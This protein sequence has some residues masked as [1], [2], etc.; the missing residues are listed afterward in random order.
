MQHVH[1]VKEH[2][3]AAALRHRCRNCGMEEQVHVVHRA[4]DDRDHLLPQL[5]D[6]RR[7]QKLAI[8]AVLLPARS[9][10][11][12][13]GSRSY[14][15][16]SAGNC[17]QCHHTRQPDSYA[18]AGSWRVGNRVLGWYLD[19]LV[20]EP[21]HVDH[22][23]GV[24]PVEI[25]LAGERTERLA[26]GLGSHASRRCTEAEGEEEERGKSET[27]DTQTRRRR[28]FIPW[29]A[30]HPATIAPT[31]TSRLHARCGPGTLRTRWEGEPAGEIPPIIIRVMNLLKPAAT[32]I[33]SK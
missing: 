23:G 16:R 4:P 22:A 11:H 1:R 30:R 24:Q 5:I 3:R 13:S 12:D 9:L 21:A 25:D 31:Y 17:P 7:V 20:E 8:N 26:E 28:R 10:R 15:R 6:R 29:R 19:I 2:A 32:A 27:L 33:P 18:I 14:R